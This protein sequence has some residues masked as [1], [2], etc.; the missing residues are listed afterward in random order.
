MSFSSF[1]VKNERHV[2]RALFSER[3]VVTAAHCIRSN[4]GL[5]DIARIGIVNLYP[6]TKEQNR[7]VIVNITHPGYRSVRRK[8]DIAIL[9]LDEP[10]DTSDPNIAFPACLDSDSNKVLGEQQNLTAIGYGRSEFY[11]KASEEVSSLNIK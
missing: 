1:F 5:F 4:G 11:R 6:E 2:K 7:R 3:V 8:N 9:I 10:V